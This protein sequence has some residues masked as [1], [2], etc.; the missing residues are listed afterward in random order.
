MTSRIPDNS[1]KMVIYD[2]ILEF[3]SFT[4]IGALWEQNP[5]GKWHK[6]PCFSN[7]YFQK[8]RRDLQNP[9]EISFTSSLK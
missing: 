8:L 7:L 6:S 5:G 9:K 1:V 3:L 2:V 4:G